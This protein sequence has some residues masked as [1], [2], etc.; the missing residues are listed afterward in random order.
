MERAAQDARFMQIALRLAKRGLGATAPNPSVGA[1]VVEEESG[2]IIARAATHP[3]GRPHAEALVLTLAGQRA[4][5]KTLY[6]SLEPCSHHGRTPP[7]VG[8]IIAAGIRRVVCPIEDPDPRVSGAGAS[9]LR[10]A[11]ITVDMGVCADDARWTAAGHILSMTQRRPFVQLKLAL[12]A[13]GLIAPGQGSPRWVTG[14]EARA[15]GHL[16]RARADAVLVGRN[17]VIDDDPELTCRLPGLEGR[18]PRRIVLD[19]HFRTPPGAKLFQSAVRVPV[20][21]IGGPTPVRASF[22][23]GTTTVQTGVDAEG[24]LDVAAVLGVLQGQGI[25]RLLV[26]GGPSVARSFLD[27]GL[28]DEAVLF[29]GSEKLGTGGREPLV[30]RDLD[31]FADASRWAMADERAIGSDRVTVYRAQHRFPEGGLGPRPRSIAD[32]RL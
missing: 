32:T 21:I 27:A 24:R 15:L 26:E 17:T 7:C 29:R 10:A 5:G 19:T 11:G 30:D 2:E 12:S 16:L 3:G 20:T 28:I 23:A 13:D 31:V 9:Q 8:A 6:V 1:L 22:P 25:T 18:S 4:R 14:P